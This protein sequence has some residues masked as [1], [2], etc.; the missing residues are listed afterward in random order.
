MAISAGEP[1]SNMRALPRA[2]MRHKERFFAALFEPGR[3]YFPCADLPS[4][5]NRPLEACASGLE[6]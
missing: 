5:N 3:A 1:D 2:P 4:S 6:V